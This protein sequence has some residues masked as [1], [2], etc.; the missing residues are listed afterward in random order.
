MG[1]MLLVVKLDFFIQT[2]VGKC[3]VEVMIEEH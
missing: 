1:I 3:K 2:F